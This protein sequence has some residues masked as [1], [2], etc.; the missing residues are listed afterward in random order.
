MIRWVPRARFMG[1]QGG[2]SGSGRLLQPLD[3]GPDLPVQ[4]AMPA[5]AARVLGEL[6]LRPRPAQF[7]LRLARQPDRAGV[8]LGR[9]VEV[10]G[11]AFRPLERRE[12][13]RLEDRLRYEG[14]RDEPLFLERQGVRGRAA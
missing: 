1:S 7:F 8:V 12:E 10:V 6:D 3:A 11:V 9:M 13:L 14:S 4:I 5:V 2:D